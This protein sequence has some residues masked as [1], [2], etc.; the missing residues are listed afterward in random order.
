[1]KKNPK[2]ISASILE[3]KIISAVLKLYEKDKYLLDENV[4]ERSISHR[5]A[6]Y[7]QSEFKEWDVDCEYNRNV[8]GTDLIKRLSCSYLIGETAST[9]DLSAK[10]VY[11]DII[12][13]Q[14]GT[15]DNLIVIEMKKNSSSTDLD[16]KDR[17]KLQSY[18]D[19]LHYKY[20]LFLKLYKDTK[21]TL[22]YLQTNLLINKFRNSRGFHNP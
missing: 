8:Q 1:M 11:P 7:L 21:T 19:E 4:N 16:N 3:D 2:S 18:I 22:K 13:H 9:S 15:E 14:R 6:G 17:R 20:G 12:I 10:T 5:L